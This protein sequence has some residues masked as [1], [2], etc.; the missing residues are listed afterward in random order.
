MV[1][2]CPSSATPILPVFRNADT[3]RLPQRRYCSSSTTST[4]RQDGTAV[5]R[6]QSGP[7]PALCT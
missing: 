4:T 3:A 7:A 1:A 2:Y 6:L 5:N